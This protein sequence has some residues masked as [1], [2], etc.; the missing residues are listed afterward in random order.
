MHL[1]VTLKDKLDVNVSED[2]ALIVCF[3]GTYYSVFAF[4]KNQSKIALLLQDLS[5]FERYG[6]P[7]GFKNLEKKLNLWSKCAFIYAFFA[8]VVYSSIKFVQRSK[9]QKNNA[10]KNLDENCGFPTAIWSPVDIN[11]FPV[12]QMVYFYVVVSIQTLMKLVL[13]I[14][15]L[16]LE[17]AHYIVLRIEHLEKMIV[18][19][20][21][22]RNT[23]IRK[24]K[25][26][27]CILY[28]TEILEYAARLS[29]CFFN[30]MFAHLTM[31]A[32]IC[33]CLEKTLID[34][35]TQVCTAIHIFG[36]IL[37]LFFACYGG[38]H[39]MSASDLFPTKIWNSLWYQAELSLQKDVMFML[40]RSQK[41]LSVAAG[42]FDVVSYSLFVSV[43]KM[44]YSIMC[45]LS[46][47]K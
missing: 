7:P 17:M 24:R 28:H 9:C 5:N 30:D 29:N 32:A 20:F 47:G 3:L 1:L 41:T 40:F 8:V 6:M 4:T 26:I 15:V 18:E 14:S 19:C 11:Y 25:M 21:E 33:G 31:T 2:V 34:E 42:P 13:M 37:S 16:M 44:S 38:Q 43:M 12:Y 35:E 22:S 36:W 10:Q 23:T 39:L 27:E 46:K 45:Y